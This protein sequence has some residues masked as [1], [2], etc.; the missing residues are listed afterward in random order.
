MIEF[1]KGPTK[2]IARLFAQAP[3]Y[4]PYREHFW[5]DWG[6][7]F[8]RGRL[9]GK[10]KL[11]CVASDPGPTE[12]IAGRALV[13][14][15]GQRVQGFLNKVGLTQ[16]YVC[17]NAFIYALYPSHYYTGLRIL[18]DPEHV[19]WRNML[20]NKLKTENLQA[21]VAFG[22]QAKVAVD[23][24]ENKDDLSVFKVPHPSSRNRQ[25]LLDE[26]RKAVIELRKV[27]TPDPDGLPLATNYTDEFREEDYT[28]IP[29]RDLPFGVPRWL[30]DDEW[31]R[32]SNPSHRN[33]VRRPKP[34]D[35]HT[36]IWIAPKT[37]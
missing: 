11:L 13:G 30:G 25:K 29:K 4:E 23:H 37:V 31:G 17:L 16:S 34:D 9:N 14:D 2:K 21:V 3:D 36:L 15:A 35:R 33:C 32:N 22:G 18:K 1:D 6:P 12:R 5:F 27:I 8:Y 7:V 24:W 26:W 28:Q 10:A 20:F 19:K